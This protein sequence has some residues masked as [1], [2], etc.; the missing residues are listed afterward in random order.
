MGTGSEYSL[1]VNSKG[2][3]SDEARRRAPP[4]PRINPQGKRDLVPLT[5]RPVRRP[6]SDVEGTLACPGWPSNTVE[7]LVDGAFRPEGQ[8]ARS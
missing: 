7:A 8:L 2:L 4:L 5:T 6:R 1:R 3:A